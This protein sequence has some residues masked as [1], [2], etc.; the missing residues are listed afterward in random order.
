MYPSPASPTGRASRYHA[1]KERTA[2][3]LTF[4]LWVLFFIGIF[5]LAVILA[6][7]LDK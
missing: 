5:G 2:M 6:I 7:V 1:G 4:W 3:D